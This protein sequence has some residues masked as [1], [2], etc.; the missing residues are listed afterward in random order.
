MK[1]FDESINDIYQK[2]ILDKHVFPEK[3]KKKIYAEQ[4][5][6][7]DPVEEEINKIPM[8]LLITDSNE[9]I[10]R[11]G[12]AIEGSGIFDDEGNSYPVGIGEDGKIYVD[13]ADEHNRT[14][15]GEGKVVRNEEEPFV[16]GEKYEP[17]DDL[18]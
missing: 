10:E 5:Y 18:K 15:T 14:I 6:E 9:L 12:V 7:L 17:E 3:E 1:V 8:A 13:M 11:S 2:E 16:A 4:E